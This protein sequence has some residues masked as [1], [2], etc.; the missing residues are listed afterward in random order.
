MRPVSFEWD[1]Y[2]EYGT[3]LGLIAQDV[4]QVVKEVVV[5]REWVIDEK[6]GQKRQTDTTSM[7]IYYADLIPVLIKAIQE[8]QEEI[9]ELKSKINEMIRK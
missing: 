5:D 3:K 7:G 1:D 4:K 8:Q 9:E 2:P 6:T